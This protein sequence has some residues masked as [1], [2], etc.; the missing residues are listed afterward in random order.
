M[1]TSGDAVTQN[2]FVTF[3]DSGQYAPI[4]DVG[5]IQDHFKTLENLVKSKK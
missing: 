4:R 3:F 5:M 1:I 2:P